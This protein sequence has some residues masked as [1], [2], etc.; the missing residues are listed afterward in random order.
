[1]I[2]E[3]KIIAIER[4]LLDAMRSLQQASVL[5]THIKGQNLE[6]KEYINEPECKD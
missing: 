4:H 2:V 5:L 3:N 6:G 1:M